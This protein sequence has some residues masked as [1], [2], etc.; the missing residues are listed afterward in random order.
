MISVIIPTHN[1]SELLIRAIQSVLNQTYENLEILVVSDGSTDNT[2]IV[3]GKLLEQDERIRFINY[4]PAKGGN[5]ARNLGI[6][7]SLGEYVAFL[8]DDDEWISTKL[9]KQLNILIHNPNIGIVYTGIKSIYVNESLDYENIPSKKG[10]LS[11][12]ILFRNYIGTTS[13]VMVR[14][15]ILK[16]VGNFDEKLKAQQDY[17]LWIRIC[18][19]YEVGLVSEPCVHYYNYTNTNQISL[20]TD[21]YF[22]SMNYIELKYKNLFNQMSKDVY[23]KRKINNYLFLSLKALRNNDKKS[24][25]NL[26]LESLK[27]KLNVKSIIYYFLS[28]T[29]YSFL[30]KLKAKI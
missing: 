17:D 10:D 22:E 2:E 20:Q 5:Y 9:E 12:E 15:S 7:E 1:R 26:A 14:K 11:K 16:E 3:M 19:K 28:F 24:A 29:N 8:D 25:R 27:I 6:K 4:Q 23:I 18:Q 21:K 13:S 30:L